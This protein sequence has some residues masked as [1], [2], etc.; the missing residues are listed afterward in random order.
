[1]STFKILFKSKDCPW[2]W[3]AIQYGKRNSNQRQI[4]PIWNTSTNTHRSLL[5]GLGFYYI[6]FIYHR[7][8]AFNQDRK[9]VLHNQLRKFYQ[10]IAWAASQ[11]H[12]RL[13]WQP[14][15]SKSK[16]RMRCTLCR[17]TTIYG[18]PLGATPKQII[19]F[20][21]LK[22]G[23]FEYK[24]LNKYKHG[25]ISKDHQCHSR[26]KHITWVQIKWRARRSN[27]V[28]KWG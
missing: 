6:E 10:L 27:R 20:K 19:L 18:Q 21:A 24:H 7:K 4:F 5:F 1:M 9:L 11:P 22:G 14:C 16:T 17:L 15:K 28:H 3:A 8:H 25:T 23:N 2:Q 13:T 12:T 26:P